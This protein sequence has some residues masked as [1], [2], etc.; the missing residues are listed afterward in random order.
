M[1]VLDNALDELAISVERL[2]NRIRAELPRKNLNLQKE[3][4]LDVTAALLAK[5]L[6]ERTGNIWKVK[7]IRKLRDYG[8]FP[9]EHEDYKVQI[10]ARDTCIDFDVIYDIT[11]GKLSEIRVF[12]R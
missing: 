4:M 8:K 5:E 2:T 12:P 10:C 6:T 9:Y 11:N 3:E 7:S 1:K